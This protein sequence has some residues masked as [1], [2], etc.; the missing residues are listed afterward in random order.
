MRFK[1]KIVWAAAFAVMLA[2]HGG[3][4]WAQSARL[5]V[6]KARGALRCGVNP[7]FAGFAL[8]DK[9]GQWHG[10]DVDMCRAVAA[11][12][13]GDAKKVQYVPLTAKD[14]F[15][16]L[17]AGDIDMLARNASWTLGRNTKLGVNFVGTNFYDGQAFMVRK[18]ANIKSAKDLDGASICTISGTDTERNLADFFGSRKMKFSSVSYENADNVSDAYFNKRCDAFLNDR[19][20]LAAVRS[21]A[22][23]PNSHMILPDVVSNEPLSISVRSGDDAW[24]NVVRWSFFAM[25]WGEELNLTSKTIDATVASTQNPSVL[26]FAGKSEDMGAMLGLDRAWAVNIIKQVG[27]YA[28][29][30]ERNI[31]PLGLERGLNRLWRD[32]GLLIAPPIR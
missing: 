15:T 12:V 1:F 25:I 7:N 9:A 13:F 23:D 16:A 3:D 17:Q 30:Y 2:S 14:R 4:V 32:G 26:R 20:Q 10:F 29:S 19:S 24:A 18:D 11:A 31:A 28:E 27:N 5:D 8:P 6:V 22:A 21:I